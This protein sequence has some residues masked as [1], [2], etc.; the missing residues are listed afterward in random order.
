MTLEK[1]LR[2]R[3]EISQQACPS[4]TPGWAGGGKAGRLQGCGRGKGTRG[5][6][7][8]AEAATATLR[9]GEPG[10]G[11]R[12]GGRLQLRSVVSE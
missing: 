5:L 6:L 8:G 12:S 7:Y 3:K 9:G 11:R 10:V 1:K 4:L 2:R